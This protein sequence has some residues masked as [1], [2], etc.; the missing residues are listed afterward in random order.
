MRIPTTNARVIDHERERLELLPFDARGSSEPDH[1]RDGDEHRR[2]EAEDRVRRRD[3]GR[4]RRRQP[5]D[6]EQVLDTQQI[7]LAENGLKAPGRS[8]P[9]G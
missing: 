5:V 7:E 1:Q 3:E 9:A 4:R 6:G 8:R 2:R